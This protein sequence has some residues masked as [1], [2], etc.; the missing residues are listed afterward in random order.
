MAINAWAN[1]ASAALSNGNISDGK[2]AAK[3]AES[4]L[5]KLQKQ[6]FTTNK[7]TIACYGAVI[8][9]WAAVGQAQ[10]A[11]TVLEDMVE[12]S[13]RIPLDLIH[14]NA[15]LDAWAR[16][17]APE[18]DLDKIISRLSSIHELLMKMDSGGYQSYNVDPDTSSFNH[19]I[20]ACYAPWT[21]HQTPEDES[22]RQKAL[23]IAYDSYSRMNQD[24]NSSHR[25][26]AHTYAHMF[27]AI[28]C[29]KASTTASNPDTHLEKY[30]FCKTILQACCRDGHLSKSSVW[31]L[32]KMFPVEDDLAELLL[33]QMDHQHG[34]NMTKEKLLS[35]PEDSLHACLP[36]EW[37]R[38]SRKYKGLNRQR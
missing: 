12:I 36:A 27:K 16:D 37:S 3:H 1:A 17:L 7:T 11:Q 30:N 28:A 29:L 32:R 22:T 38:H 15:V 23:E 24:Y 5:N 33:S 34:N 8:R 31:T 18:R 14:F 9:T 2:I 10:R 35:V 25:P 21:S 20:R 6:T 4:L 13:E 19:V 26:D